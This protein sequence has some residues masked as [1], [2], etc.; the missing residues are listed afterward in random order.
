MSKNLKTRTDLD[1]PKCIV[2]WLIVH[3]HEF[4]DWLL[5]SIPCDS[6]CVHGS[7]NEISETSDQYITD[8]AIQ[9]LTRYVE[10][11]KMGTQDLL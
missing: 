2:K 9:K 6:Y 8:E 10:V 3:G 4:E 11:N 1:T 5:E 7:E